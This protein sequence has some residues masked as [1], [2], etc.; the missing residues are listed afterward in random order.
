MIT[1][2]AN[3]VLHNLLLIIQ[4]TYLLA[5]KS[6]VISLYAW[7]WVAGKNLEIVDCGTIKL[8]DSITADYELRNMST[9]LSIKADAS[10][11]SL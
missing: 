6:S 2:I 3:S 11:L 7:K 9:N 4:L 1:I 5:S 8:L 10:S